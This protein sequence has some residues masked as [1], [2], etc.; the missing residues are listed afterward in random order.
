[1][2]EKLSPA[3]Q[4]VLDAWRVAGRAPKYHR[5]MQ[6]ILRREWPVLYYALR[7]LEAEQGEK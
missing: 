2:S 6:E 1:M 7:D 3:A 4:K 5:E